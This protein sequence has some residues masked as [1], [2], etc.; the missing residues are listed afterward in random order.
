MGVN[1]LV[2]GWLDY[3]IFGVLLSVSLLIGIYFG[4]FSKQ[5]STSE[6]LFGGK[7]MHYIPVAASILSSFLSGIT[8][9]GVP[10][11]V[12]LHGSQY[13][14]TVFSSLAIGAV[15]AYLILPVFY[16]LRLSSCYEYLELRFS[17]NVRNFTSILYIAQLLWYIPVVI[18]VPALAFSQV[19]GYNLH[20]ITPILSIVC[21]IYTSMGG[22]KAVVWTDTIQFIFTIGGLTTVLIL[23][24]ISIHGFSEI[25]RIADEGGRIKIFDM[26][27]NPFKR[28][29]FWIIIVGTTFG[30]LTRFA[31][32]Q[33][34][35]QR[36]LAIEKES[37]MKKAIFL[38]TIGWGILQT[39]CI[40][41]GL[42]MYA[43]YHGCDPLKAKI[44]KES[45][46]TLPYYVM[47]VSGH[48]FGLPGIFI[49]G[50]VSSALSTMSASLNTLSGLIYSTFVD[51]WIPE[52]HKK[53]STAANVMKVL[54]IIIGAI[55]I[56]LIFIIERLGT[57]FEMAMSLFSAVEGVILGLFLS[58]LF[59]PGIGK[60]G[61]IFGGCFSFL[62]MTWFVSMTRWYILNGRIR[63]SNLPT[64]TEICP[65]P[66]NETE[67]SNMTIS[68]SISVEDEPFIIFH[69]SL[70]YYTFIGGIITIAIGL[71]TSYFSGEMNTSRVNPDHFSPII[72]RLLPQDK[73]YVGVPIEVIKKKSDIRI[74]T[75]QFN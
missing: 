23:G 35:V 32:G 61:A 36:Y 57:V 3:T 14:I 13:I 59:I 53:D 24:V 71:I 2:F 68:S 60:R 17:K 31:F 69:I 43:H 1:L 15:A 8:Y 22:V 55:T 63:Y 34:F 66:L 52:N 11:E 50:L 70:Y 65:Y 67:L 4:L 64:S 26:D 47:D 40:F 46:Q 5:D 42:I 39:A 25:W 74:K 54:S 9:L 27:P 6:Y 7:T 28:D 20:V 18:Y 45:D 73:I 58:G 44:I 33:K 41:L 48:L 37:E 72:R 51:K 19:T 75:R 12:Y 29:S 62:S 38:T 16:N 30:F 10:T 21:I 49:A 56:G